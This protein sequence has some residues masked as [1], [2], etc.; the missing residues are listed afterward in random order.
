MRYEQEMQQRWIARRDANAFTEL[1]QQ[2]AGMVFATC[3][4]VLGDATEAEDVAQECFMELA[5]ATKVVKPSLG[6]W[7]HRV[8]VFRSLN[9]IRADHRR[10]LRE[11]TYSEAHPRTTEAGWDDIKP[12]LDEAIAALPDKFRLAVIHRFLE[13]KSQEDV[14]KSLGVSRSTAQYRIERGVEE[15]RAFLKGRG[16][17]AAASALVALLGTR[18]V[19]AAPAKLTATLGQRALAAFPN[20]LVVLGGIFGLAFLTWPTVVKAV[21]FAALGAGM[22]VFQYQK[23]FGTPAAIPVDQPSISATGPSPV[24]TAQESSGE[25]T[26]PAEG[27]RAVDL[28]PGLGSAVVTGRVYASENG[29]ALGAFDVSAYPEGTKLDG[30]AEPMVSARTGD[31]GFYELRD[32]SAGDYDVYAYDSSISYNVMI[33]SEGSGSSAPMLGGQTEVQIDDA[34]GKTNVDIAVDAGRCFAGQVVFGNG[35]PAAGVTVWTRGENSEAKYWAERI[36]DANGHVLFIGLEPGAELYLQASNDGFASPVAGPFQVN[37][38]REGAVVLRLDAAASIE[39]LVVDS[40]GAPAPFAKVWLR[41]DTAYI[42]HPRFLIADEAGHFDLRGLAAGD[43]DVLLAPIG[44]QRIDEKT[45]TLHF[46]WGSITRVYPDDEPVLRLA[47]RPGDR[48]EGLRIGARGEE[49]SGRVTDIEGK[50]I[51]GASISIMARAKVQA[52]TSGEFTIAGVPEGVYSVHAFHEDYRPERLDDVPSG[53]RDVEF[54]LEKRGVVEGQVV[55]ARTGAPIPAFSLY[56]GPDRPYE[57]WMEASFKEHADLEGRFT[58]KP[59]FVT[60]RIFA[61]AKGYATNS[62]LATDVNDGQAPTQITIALEPASVLHGTVTRAEG[63]PVA[64]ASVFLGAVPERSRRDVSALAQTDATGQ[65]TVDSLS[66]DSVVLV[67]WHAQYGY[68]KAST[69]GAAGGSDVVKIVL[70]QS[71]AL[72]GFITSDGEPVVGHGVMALTM[73]EVIA[74]G[75]RFTGPLATGSAETDDEGKFRFADLPTGNV[76]ITCNWE[77]RNRSVNLEVVPGETATA[78]IDFPPGSATLEGHIRPE[79]GAPAEV[80]TLSLM[81]SSPLGD[82]SFHVESDPEG[83]YQ[84][85]ALPA[86][87]YEVLIRIGEGIPVKFAEPLE[88]E[89]GAA[90]VRDFNAAEGTPIGT[91][92]ESET[93]QIVVPPIR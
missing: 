18:T 70:E 3:R 74:P 75:E 48:R 59:N 81:L 88:I 60:E 42:V 56:T 6:G 29:E 7:L 40:T 84:I 25:V 35:D 22:L 39:G 85:D 19:E 9:R 89:D 77:R 53:T 27:K 11:K 73:P 43:Y 31:D 13:G 23:N 30:T 15:I 20:A 58:Y 80:A 65:F 41:P 44:S 72:E 5:G 2:H 34:G 61:R 36:S 52:G 33:K 90:V 4:R 93:V 24:A 49:I 50:P 63:T 55:D 57:S 87:F 32:L 45:N 67:A 51:P 69:P 71:G 62:A 12:H 79:E 78:A 54:V 10:K 47:L 21:L 46:H 38:A 8:A 66:G 16:I 86:G 1:V 92:T 17:T 64:N 76:Q 14:A 26:A 82:E 68:G 37:E 91:P 83:N 28:A